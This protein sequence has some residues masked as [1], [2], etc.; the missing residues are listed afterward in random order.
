MAFPTKLETYEAM[1]Y[2][3]KQ[4]LITKDKRVIIVEAFW[5]PY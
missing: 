3:W 1:K 2:G 5:R 4:K